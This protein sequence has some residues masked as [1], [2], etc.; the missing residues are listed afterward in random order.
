VIQRA[1]VQPDAL[2]PV[3]PCQWEAVLQENASGALAD[4]RG[5]HAKERQL[6]VR[7]AAVELQQS[8][9]RA[10]WGERENIDR[11]IVKNGVKF[12]VGQAKAAELQPG[13]P[14]T[15]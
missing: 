10:G 2:R 3:L 9:V 6:N 8:V 7:K 15:R 12:G 1:G 13:S 14:M 11:G 5:R 4:E